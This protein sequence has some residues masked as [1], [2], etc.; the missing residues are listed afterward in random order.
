MSG[1]DEVGPEQ[2]REDG[3]VRFVGLDLGSGDRL[4]A[5][6]VSE[7]EL[8]AHAGERIGQPVPGAGG[9]HHRLMRP[10]DLGAVLLDGERGASHAGLFDAWTVRSVRCD[11][12]VGLVLVNAGVPH[13]V[14]SWGDGS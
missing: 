12:A 9:L 7:D 14:P 13:G 3:G 6:R 11:H 2:E 8:D 5:R 10:R 4:Y 1:R